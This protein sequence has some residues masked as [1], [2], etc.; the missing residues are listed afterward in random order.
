MRVNPGDDDRH[1][2]F[3][4]LIFPVIVVLFRKL[5]DAEV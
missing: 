5:L 2:P 3:E 4:R 1:W